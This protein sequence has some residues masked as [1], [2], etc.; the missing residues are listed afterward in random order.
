MVIIQRG[1]LCLLCPRGRKGVQ[2][3]GDGEGEV[4]MTSAAT[5]QTPP[6]KGL[7]KL[8]VFPAVC[9]IVPKHMGDDVST[10]FWH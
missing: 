9:A 10:Y 2:K 3:C 6:S 5:C 8:N 4:A 1:K 7:G